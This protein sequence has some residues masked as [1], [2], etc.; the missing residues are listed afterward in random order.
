MLIAGEQAR[1]KVPFTTSDL[2]SWREEVKCFRKDPEGVA[3][4]FKLIAKN[5]DIDWEDIDVMLSELTETEKE[6]VLKKARTHATLLPGDVKN[7]FPA[8]N[9]DWDPNNTI[10]YE[11]LIQYRKLI[12]LG[13]RNAIPKAINWAALYD[14][15]RDETPSEFLDRLRAAMRQ[16]TP[17]DPASEA[18]DLLITTETEED[19]V[20]WTISLLN[21]LG[22]NGYRV[23][24][25]KAQLVQE[26]VVYLGYKISGGQRSLGTARKEA[27]CQMPRPETVR[28]LRTFLGMTEGRM[29]AEPIEHDCLETIE[30]VYSSDPDLKEEPFEDA[31][32]WFSDG[33]S[34]VKQGVRMAGYAGT[35]TEHVIES[36]PL[37]AG[38]STQKTELIALT[39]ALDLTEGR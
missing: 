17:L 23:S 29:S 2:N 31:D 28:D 15:R 12:V 34:F 38:T 5:Q 36:N 24:Q 39:R 30:T 4:R 26:K 27:I 10:Q 16:Y 18:D 22:L 13:L 20:E 19:C 33:S 1:V 32:N 9:P 6:L 14:I 8:E 35:T 11:W 7:I 37:P 3:R 25:Q 21:F